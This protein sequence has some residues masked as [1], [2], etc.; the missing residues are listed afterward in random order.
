MPY[1]V[2]TNIVVDVT[3]GSAKAEDYLDSLADAWSISMITYLEFLVGA[4]TQRETNDLD[5]VLSGYR[6][7]PPN[8]DATRRAYY[9]I[10]TYARSHGLDTLDA[11]IAATALEEGLTLATKNRKHFQMIGDLKLEVPDY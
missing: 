7:I 6:A 10:K 5:L 1:L 3:R 11:P 4:R 8:E 9:L 2:D